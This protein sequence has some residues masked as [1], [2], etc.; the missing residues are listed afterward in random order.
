MADR[1]LP[2]RQPSAGWSRQVLACLLL[3][4]GAALP[5]LLREPINALAWAL[6]LNLPPWISGPLLQL[7]PLLWIAAVIAG[8]V[9]WLRL[10][11]RR[12]CQARRLFSRR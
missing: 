12:E 5:A 6:V 3:G 9:L 10:Q 11:A 8:V 7:L 2:R 1:P 4:L